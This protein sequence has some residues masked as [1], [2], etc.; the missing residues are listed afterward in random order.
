MLKQISLFNLVVGLFSIS[1]PAMAE[2]TT[3]V[4]SQQVV[5][6]PG[7]PPA[8]QQSTFTNSTVSPTMPT[9]TTTL[10]L[11]QFLKQLNSTVQLPNN[12]AITSIITPNSTVNLSLDQWKQ[13][14]STV[15]IPNNMMQIPSAVIITL[16]PTK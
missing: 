16:P 15:Q 11:D 3:V 10:S 6:E 8:V 13:L 12:L 2:Q 9:A 4:Q 1:V 7:K 14:N 5:T